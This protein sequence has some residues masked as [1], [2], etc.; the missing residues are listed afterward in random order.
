MG[1]DGGGK[2]DYVDARVSCQQ[3]RQV[4]ENGYRLCQPSLGRRVGVRHGDEFD[5]AGFLEPCEV[6][7]VPFTEAVDAYQGYAWNSRGVSGG[8]VATARVRAAFR[9]GGLLSHEGDP[10]VL[11]VDWE[12]KVDWW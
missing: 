3:L 5:G 11:K 9:S 2:N 12:L 6:G 1:L 8:R 10:C 7:Q 4:I